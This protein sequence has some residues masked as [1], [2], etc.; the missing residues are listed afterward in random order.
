[1]FT[2]YNKYNSI[3]GRF[4]VCILINI[5]RFTCRKF[6]TSIMTVTLIKSKFNIHFWYQILKNVTC[7][8]QKI[9]KKYM[10]ALI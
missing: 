4:I 10:Y 1:M 9:M 8:M 2:K 6:W 5:N 3:V 7:V